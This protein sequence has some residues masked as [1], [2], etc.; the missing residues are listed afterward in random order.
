M[1]KKICP[2]RE[3][4]QCTDCGKMHRQGVRRVYF[5]GWSDNCFD[6]FAAWLDR[7]RLNAASESA[8][9]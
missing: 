1:P 5:I 7:K 6:C 8:R 2:I 3:R 4:F 9:I